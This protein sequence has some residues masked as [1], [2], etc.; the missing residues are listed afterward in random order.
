[1]ATLREKTVFSGPGLTVTVTES[2]ELR[3]GETDHSRY[4]N[5]RLKAVNVAVTDGDKTTTYDIEDLLATGST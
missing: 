2:L 4:L 3:V 1:M 5:G